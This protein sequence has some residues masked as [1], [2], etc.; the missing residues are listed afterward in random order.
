MK[1]VIVGTAY[2]LRGGIAHFNALLAKHLGIHHTVETVTFKRQY[3]K[4][5]FPGKTQDEAG[6]PIDVAEA[7]Q[8]VDSINPLN[9]LKVAKIIKEKKP[10]L[11]IFKYWLPFFGPCFGTIAKLVKRKSNTKVLFICDN[12]IPHERRFGDVV[13]TKYAFKQANYFIV[14]SDAVERDLRKY[15]PIA[16]YCKVP[17]P[18]YENF[19]EPMNKETARTNLGINSKKVILYFGY[20]RAYKGLLVL[21]DAMKQLDDVQLLAVGEY[22]DDQK[23]Y[24]DKV[25]SF[26]LESRIKFYPDYIPNDQVALYFSA[27]DIV[28][29]P[30]LSATQSGITQ[31]AY[32]FDKPVIATNVGGLAEVVIDG[33][34]GYVVPPNDAA[35]LASAIKRFY[36]EKN[37]QEFVAMVKIEKTKYSWENFIRA[38]EGLMETHERK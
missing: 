12:I 33:R 22:Y 19:G 15:F 17:H 10:D 14:Q 32:N 4:F 38:I 20:V 18:V 35:A 26:G 27:A 29:L 6:A 1:I 13:F 30:Y 28:V 37:E 8:L 24:V 11:L 3:P 31:I 7:P 34:T 5:L 25:K 23:K 36:T 2:P 21:F 16:H 9:W